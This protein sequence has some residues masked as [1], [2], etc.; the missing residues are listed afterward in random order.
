MATTVEGSPWHREANVLV[1][2]EMVVDEFIKMTDEMHASA[3]SDWN[4]VDYLAGIAC[5]F[6]DT[7]KPKCEIEKFSEA[8]GKYRAY[9]GHELMSARLFES[10]ACQHDPSFTA[11]DIAFVTFFIEHHKPW[12]M[13]DV[14]KLK[15]MARTAKAYGKQQFKHALLADQKGRTSDNKAE[16]YAKCELWMDQFMT[17]DEYDP[18]GWIR[19][20]FPLNLYMPIAPSGAGKST[21]LAKLRETE[22]DLLVFSLDAL[23]H[24]FYDL[25]DYAKAYEGSVKDKSFEARANA[26]FH[27]M[28]KEHKSIYVDNTNLSAKRRKFYLEAARKYGMRAVAILM[29]VSLSVVIERQT[30]R[31]DKCVPKDA[32][33]RQYNSL[34]VPQLGEFDSIVVSD[35]NLEVQ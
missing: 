16:N 14:K 27:A 35:H 28:L 7:G 20:T 13:T 18:D 11:S 29:P 31:G 22:P 5:V 30:N 21:Y 19:Q 15:M 24:E 1:H 26:R 8:R 10:Y 34:Q 9:H 23:R 32:V 4:R 17:L 25:N 3:N 2:T 33:I 6:H 12:E